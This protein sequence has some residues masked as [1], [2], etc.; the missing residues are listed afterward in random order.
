MEQYEYLAV[1]YGG[2]NV[3][4]LAQA[5]SELDLDRL[6]ETKGLTLV[7]A[8][9][10][11]V[12]ALASRQGFN[13]SELVFFTTQ[14][15]TLLGAGVPMLAGL[16]GVGGR[17]RTTRGR[18]LVQR[19]AASLESGNSLSESL[20]E[21]PKSFPEV[22]REC[23]RAGEISG[24]LPEVLT[25]L[26]AY[27]EWVR[28]IRVT[29]MQALVYPVLLMTAILGLIIVLLTFVL[30]RLMKLF[31]GGR[32]DLPRETRIVMG[33]SDFLVGNLAAIGAGAVVCAA[34][35]WIGRRSPKI[36]ERCAGWSLKVPR[37]G[38]LARML[39]TSR[40]ASTAG[41][42]QGAGCDIGTVLDVAGRTCGNA[43]MAASFGRV[44]QRVRSGRTITESLEKEGEFDPL[45]IQM[46]HIGETSGDLSSS[47][48]QLA[49]YYDEEVPR[50]VK[51][52]LALMEPAMLIG[53][54]LI[55][56]FILLATLM[57][58]FSLYDK[59]G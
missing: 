23:V 4:G 28:A 51:W 24:A 37:Y 32:A 15:A 33:L 11:K 18:T 59:L 30:P 6:L 46:T 20:K 13:R 40:F 52:F 10:S 8:K 58:I 49:D 19:M 41:T 29:T 36:R 55:V 2:Q 5:K 17:M 54:A 1:T 57:P 26:S 34:L 3:T 44:S 21:D 38:D 14:V 53:A 47:W 27:L 31:P 56:S 48:R 25:R 9:V 16:K 39:A 45:L 7:K 50:T 22:Y 43:H 35:V 42:L 12:G